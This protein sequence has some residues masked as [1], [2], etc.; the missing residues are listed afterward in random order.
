VSAVS[1]RTDR[2]LCYGP[3]EDQLAG[4]PA[5]M[6]VTRREQPYP[7]AQVTMFEAEDGWH[8]TLNAAGRCAAADAAIWRSPPPCRESTPS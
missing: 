2:L 5:S 6:S 8:R 4:W 1:Q 3:G 7:G